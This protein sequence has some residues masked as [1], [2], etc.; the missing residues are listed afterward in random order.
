MLLLV[1]AVLVGAVAGVVV[2]VA[3]DATDSTFVHAATIGNENTPPALDEIDSK[4]R[5]MNKHI[6]VAVMMTG[7]ILV[8][9][10]V[11][12]VVVGFFFFVF[13]DTGPGRCVAG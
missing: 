12:V 1:L 8:L 10:V 9:V 13:D 2:A 4:N 11:V 3:V 5:I 6:H 7:T